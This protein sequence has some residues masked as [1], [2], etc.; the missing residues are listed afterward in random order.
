MET[1]KVQLSGG[2][3]YTVSIPKY[4]A[5]EHGIEAGSVLE[6]HPQGDGSLLVDARTDNETVERTAEVNISTDGESEI[7]RRLNAAY[8]VGGES[9]DLIDR[10]DHPDDRCQLI[11]Q[12]LG[13]FSGFEVLE[14]TDTH[15]RVQNLLKADNID[16]RKTTLRLSLITLA[17]HRDAVTAVVD[18]DDAL[19]R[20]VIERDTEADKLFAIVVRHFRRSLTDLTEIKK[21]GQS[22]DELFEHY[23][24]ARQLE[25]VADHAVKIARFTHEPDASFPDEYAEVFSELGTAARGVV[26]DAADAVFTDAGIATPTD[27]LTDRDRV[28]ERINDLDRDLYECDDPGEAYVLGLLLDSH[29]RTAEYGANIAEVALQQR[30]RDVAGQ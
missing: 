13:G 4:W 11:E 12:A 25:R 10:S 22:R 9:L 21:L 18:D 26:D 29:R 8:T 19:A 23:Y 3:T 1:R 20:R 2:T 6:I 5:K 7:R 16:I 15:I 30:T 17:M 24:T 28:I 14:S 27:A